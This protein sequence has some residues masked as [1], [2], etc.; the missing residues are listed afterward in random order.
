[1]ILITPPVSLQG[2]PCATA[3]ARATRGRRFAPRNDKKRVVITRKFLTRQSLH[4]SHLYNRPTAQLFFQKNEQAE[5]SY[6]R[7][8]ID[9]NYFLR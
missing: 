5:L 9:H 3:E 2:G 7:R 4:V 6:E 8:P 1:M